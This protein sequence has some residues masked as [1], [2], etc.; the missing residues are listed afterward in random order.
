MLFNMLFNFIP[1]RMID[2]TGIQGQLRPGRVPNT[3]FV[4]GPGDL[5]DE[6]LF[7]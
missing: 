6:V 5:L 4:G 7:V 3:Y 1:R 2:S